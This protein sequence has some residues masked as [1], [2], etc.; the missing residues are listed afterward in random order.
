MV[1]GIESQSGKRLLRTKSGNEITAEAIVAGIGIGPNTVLAQNAGLAVDN[2]IL[3]DEYLRTNQPDIYAAGD[4][5]NFFNPLL[6]KRLRVE[7]EDNANTMGKLAGQNMAASQAEPYHHLP[8]FYSDLFELGYEAVGELT[9]RLETFPTGRS[10][11]QRRVYY[12]DKGRV[13]G[14][15]LWNVWDQVDNARK[16]IAEAGPFKPENLGKIA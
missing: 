13:R 10:I 1:S 15:L 8:Y 12:L 2:G 16:L 4:A 3:V 9:P 11:P 5:A 14:V 6:G 7:H